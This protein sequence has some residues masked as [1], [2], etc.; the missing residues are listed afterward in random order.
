MAG[1]SPTAPVLVDSNILIDLLRGSRRAIATL[2]PLLDRSISIVTWIELMSGPHQSE[3]AIIA[4]LNDFGLLPL[5]SE[6]AH[7]AAVVRREHRLKL[8]DAVIVATARVHDRVLLTR[9]RKD[10]AGLDVF[11]P[12]EAP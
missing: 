5:T 1:L 10:L 6:I 3:S 8:P 11:T 2:E 12:Y 4:V 9:D 7:A